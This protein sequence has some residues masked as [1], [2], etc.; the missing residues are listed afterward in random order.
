MKEK[1]YIAYGSNLNLRQMADRCPE[2]MPVGVAM[3]DGWQLT[4]RCVAT[5]EKVE[6]ATTP[7]GIWKITDRCEKALDRYEGYPTLYRKEYIEVKHKGEKLEA[8]IYLMN[9]GLPC[10]PSRHYL[11][12]IEQGY[13]D[14]RLDT[15]YLRGALEHTQERMQER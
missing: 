14:S 13:N 9:T 12:T 15:A 6:G 1:L 11:Q 3:L 7:V 10:M 8:M 5:L 4:F 2:A